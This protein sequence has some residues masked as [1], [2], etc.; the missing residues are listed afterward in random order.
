MYV[1]VFIGTYVVCSPPGSKDLAQTN[2]SG[3]SYFL[4]LE[5]GMVFPPN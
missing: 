2:I 4:R 3:T 1:C 5:I